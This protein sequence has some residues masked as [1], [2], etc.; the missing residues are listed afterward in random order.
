MILVS[1]AGYL[2]LSA[3]R[4]NSTLPLVSSIT[5]AA[6]FAA[7]AGSSDAAAMARKHSAPT[8]NVRKRT[9]VSPDQKQERVVRITLSRSFR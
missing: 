9:A 8:S 1:E 3:L 6:Y 5:M 4:A 7:R 2:D